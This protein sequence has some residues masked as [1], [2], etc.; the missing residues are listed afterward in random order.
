MATAQ[1]LF[2]ILADM[3]QSVLGV[4]AGETGA[5]TER[6]TTIPMT[7][8]TTACVSTSSLPYLNIA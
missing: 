2:R 1:K 5:G 6:T 8:A 4:A 3:L 7:K